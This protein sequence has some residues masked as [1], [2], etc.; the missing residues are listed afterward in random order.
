MQTTTHRV[1]VIVGSARN[2]GN[3][4]GLAAWLANVA[5][6]QFNASGAAIELVTVDPQEHPEPFGPVL[7]GSRFPGQVKNPDDYI[8]PAIGEWSRFISS[9]SALAIVS[10][11]YNGGYPGQLKN[12]IDQL[13]HEWSNKPTLLLTYGSGGGLRAQAQLQ[14]ILQSVKLQ[15]LADPVA[16]KLPPSF[17]GGKDRVLSTGG[18][19]PEFLSAHEPGVTK[20]LLELS[21]RLLNPKVSGESN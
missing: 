5:E 19:F 9:C 14:S 4:A 18:Q 2:G 21:E 12:S 6:R 3:G 11:E 20:A 16:V 10:P 15:V 13:Y 1:A 17:I 8:S 7:D